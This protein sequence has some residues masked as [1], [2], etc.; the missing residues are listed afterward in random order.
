MASKALIMAH[1][2]LFN[3]AVLKENGFYFSNADEVKELLLTVKKED[4]SKQVQNN[5]E[6]IIKEFNWDK[7]NGDYLR[8]FEKSI[9][10]IDASA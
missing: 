4:Y 2:N 3:K 9:S 10:G 1:N 8:L 7:I 5:F 6:T